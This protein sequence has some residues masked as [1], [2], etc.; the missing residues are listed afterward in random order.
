MKFL[1]DMME[2]LSEFYNYK[3]NLI[4]IPFKYLYFRDDKY[5]MY[6]SILHIFQGSWY[7]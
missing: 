6:T 2:I 7:V 1:Q 3:V 5:F 4:V